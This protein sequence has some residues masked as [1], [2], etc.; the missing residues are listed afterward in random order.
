VFSLL[1]SDIGPADE[2]IPLA[3]ASF[4]GES[5]TIEIDGE[6][7]TY[8]A[9]LGNDLIEAQRGKAGTTPIEHVAGTRVS[10]IASNEGGAGGGRGCAIT[11]GH[12]GYATWLPVVAA[13]L[14]WVRCRARGPRSA[15][16][17]G[18]GPAQVAVTPKALRDMAQ[19][20]RVAATR[21][22]MRMMSWRRWMGSD[23]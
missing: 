14:A 20:R 12:R 6:R 8:R 10:V 18:M 9:K 13:V 19:S 4:F 1:A 7:I 11:P 2:S 5:G 21:K 15:E 22:R 16:T 17:D 23:S 3:D